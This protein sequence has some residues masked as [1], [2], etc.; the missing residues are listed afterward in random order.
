[1]TSQ[2]ITFDLKC[3]LRKKRKLF[4]WMSHFMIT[5][6]FSLHYHPV[7][8][9]Y[10]RQVNFSVCSCVGSGRLGL[11]TQ[12]LYWFGHH[13]GLT[14]SLR[15]CSI[16]ALIVGDTSLGR[17]RDLGVSVQYSW[18][19]GCVF[20]LAVS[21]VG[22]PIVR[23]LFYLMP[24]FRVPNVHFWPSNSCLIWFWPSNSKTRC[25]RPSNS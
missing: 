25:L 6:L 8:I 17:E 2:S 5:K 23:W 1:V 9:W 15:E 3:L 22:C 20:C 13:G 11:E 10:R 18:V 19:C 4:A 24:P 21:I 16:C 12:G 7:G 14:S